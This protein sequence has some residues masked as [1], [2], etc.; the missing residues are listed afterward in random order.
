ML[1]AMRRVEHEPLD[2]FGFCVVQAAI[3]LQAWIKPPADS[4]AG[5]VQSWC[6]FG[7]VH[8]S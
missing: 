6:V 1:L 4:R 7:I 2:L 3:P 5:N 8:L